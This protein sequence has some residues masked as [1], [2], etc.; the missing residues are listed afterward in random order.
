VKKSAGI[1]FLGARIVLLGTRIEFLSARIEFLG[2]RIV[3]LGARI[4]F[5]GARIVLLGTGIQFL[6]NRKKEEQKEQPPK[7]LAHLLLPQ[8]TKP[9][10]VKAKEQAIQRLCYPSN[11]TQRQPS[12]KKE[13]TTYNI[14]FI[15][16]IFWGRIAGLKSHTFSYLCRRF[17]EN[18]IF[19]PQK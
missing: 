4:E 13:T 9:T 5:L 2:A 12:P 7:L 8:H 10:Q 18:R 19:I 17:E 3:L 16:F 6:H 15:K 14:R 11:N 1:V